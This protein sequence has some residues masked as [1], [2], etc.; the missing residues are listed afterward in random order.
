MS[1]P[2]APGIQH[3][4]PAKVKEDGVQITEA[5]MCADT[6]VTSMDEANE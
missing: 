5:W 6:S 4:A 2:L 1:P 3:A